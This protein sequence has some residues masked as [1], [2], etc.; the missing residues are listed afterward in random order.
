MFLIK[1]QTVYC[2]YRCILDPKFPKNIQYQFLSL[3]QKIVV[4]IKK[5]TFFLN[6]QSQRMDISYILK[7]GFNYWYW[8]GRQVLSYTL[9]VKIYLSRFF[10]ND[11]F[12]CVVTV[13]FYFD[14]E[15]IL[16]N[17]FSLET[18]NFSVFC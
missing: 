18:E 5:K 12:L 10:R 11:Y 17:F 14:Q 6:C 2:Y 4:R 3:L 15:S 7:V 13:Q 9:S 8:Y 16:P 1:F